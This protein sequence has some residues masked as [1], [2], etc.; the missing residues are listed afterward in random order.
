MDFALR[1]QP[2][3]RFGAKRSVKQRYSS[4]QLIFHV[5]DENRQRDTGERTPPIT[6]T[7]HKLSQLL[8]ALGDH[9]CDLGGK[10][11]FISYLLVVQFGLCLIA[12]QWMVGVIFRTFTSE[13]LGTTGNA[14]EISKGDSSESYFL[15]SLKISL[16]KGVSSRR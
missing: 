11:Q 9:L 10:K 5:L 14:S 4:H 1:C 8:L 12:S 6:R 3:W 15:G 16:A 13:K 7:Y 2:T